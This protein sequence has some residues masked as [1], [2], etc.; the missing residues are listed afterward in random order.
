VNLGAQRALGIR[1]KLGAPLTCW[2]ESEFEPMYAIADSLGV[3]LTCDPVITP[4][5]VGDSSP[6]NVSPSTDGLRRLFNG[7]L[8]RAATPNSRD[9][10]VIHEETQPPL[11]HHC[12]AGLMNVAVDP[13]GNVYPCVAWRGA[14]GNLHEQS[15]RE[16]GE[17]SQMLPEVR[18]GT[19]LAKTMLEQEG[20]IGKHMA[21]C[22]VLAVE[23]TGR[24]DGVVE[25]QLEHGRL[26]MET[27]QRHGP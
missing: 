8:P 17:R 5:D 18:N 3:P 1:F 20:P 16:I 23:L 9:P 19:A 13:L 14:A 26:A 10:P 25:A 12:G 21:F 15:I 22:P 2:N 27:I 24:P 7:Q 11:A 6:M 4:R